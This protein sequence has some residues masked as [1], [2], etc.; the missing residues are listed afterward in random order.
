M[1]A[2]DVIV[3]DARKR[4]PASNYANSIAVGLAKKIKLFSNL[5]VI[6]IDG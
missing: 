2:P 6:C 1:R 4:L 3:I 5:Q